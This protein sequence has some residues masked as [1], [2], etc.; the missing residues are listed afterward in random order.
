[1]RVQTDGEEER[2]GK[3]RMIRIVNWAQ[4]QHYKDRTPPWIKLHRSLL[5]NREWCALPDSAARLLPELWLLASETEDGTVRADS[6][7]LAWRLRRASGPSIAEDLKCLSDKG[8]IQLPARGASGALA[9]RLQGACP[10]AEGETE[11]ET[12]GEERE[13]RSRAPATDNLPRFSELTDW[14]G[15]YAGAADAMAESAE[16]GDQWARAVWGQFGPSGTEWHLLAGL[17]PPGPQRALAAAL[18]SYAGEGRRYRANFFRSFVER[19]AQQQAEGS[20]PIAAVTLSSSDQRILDHRRRLEKIPL[21][22]VR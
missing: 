7:W 11:V 17:D 8:F 16:H 4:F 6:E 21:E 10:E 19:C 14:L 9:D 13:R 18:L 1:M 12:E 15:E 2:V 22:V 5:D 3:E 20:D